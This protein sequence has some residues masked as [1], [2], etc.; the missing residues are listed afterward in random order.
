MKRINRRIKTHNIE[1]CA[2]LKKLAEAL[3]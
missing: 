3:G 2:D 1:T